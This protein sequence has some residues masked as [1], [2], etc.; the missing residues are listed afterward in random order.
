MFES[1]NVALYEPARAQSPSHPIFVLRTFGAPD[2]GTQRRSNRWRRAVAGA[3]VDYRVLYNLRH[4]Y[5]TLMIQAGKPL[6]WIAFQ[7]GHVGVKKIDEVYG[8]WTRLPE[9][10]AL[11]LDAFFLQIMRLPKTLLALQHLPNLSQTANEP[12]PARPKS[13]RFSRDFRDE[14]ARAGNRTRIPV[15][16]RP[17]KGGQNTTQNYSW[18]AVQVCFDGC[19][20]GPFCRQF[21]H[22]SATN[23]SHVCF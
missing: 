21:C 22:K 16:H 14:Y 4:T 1:V 12:L 9:E 8:R 5:T 18:F 13:A 10:E 15:W 23:F 11:D 7:L 3:W 17:H 19:R 6:Q 2:A 20:E